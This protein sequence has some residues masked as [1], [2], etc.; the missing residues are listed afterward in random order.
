[1]GQPQLTWA[2]P[3]MSSLQMPSF[4]I[5]KL[6]PIK[7]HFRK[8]SLVDITLTFVQFELWCA[9]ADILEAQVP[10]P[11]EETMQADP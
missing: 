8:F 9:V 5:L 7:C 3:L 4:H 10:S 11:A 1:M 6:K 2:I